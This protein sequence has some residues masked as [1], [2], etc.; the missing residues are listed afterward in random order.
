MN[1]NDLPDPIRRLLLSDENAGSA[2]IEPV[3]DYFTAC[4]SEVLEQFTGGARFALSRLRRRLGQLA[5][6]CIEVV[7][8]SRAGGEPRRVRKSVQEMSGTLTEL[9]AAWQRHGGSDP[10]SKRRRVDCT[11]LRDTESPPFAFD[12]DFSIRPGPDGLVAIENHVVS[13]DPLLLAS[14]AHWF[15]AVVVREPGLPELRLPEVELVRDA[16]H[17]RLVGSQWLPLHIPLVGA[18]TAPN[19][20]CLRFVVAP[21]S[22]DDEGQ[23]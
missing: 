6:P 5:S 23:S 16:E 4:S 13:T 3:A 14:D 19:F 22:I 11:N 10:R 7:E 17:D 21:R 15:F 8:Q 18:D 1:N 2:P 12:V 9:L 20:E